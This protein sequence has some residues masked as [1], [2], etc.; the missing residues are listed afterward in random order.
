LYHTVEKITT[1]YY[2]HVIVPHSRENHNNLVQTRDCATQ[3]RQLQRF[4]TDT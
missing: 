1:T 3:R 2:R 4:S